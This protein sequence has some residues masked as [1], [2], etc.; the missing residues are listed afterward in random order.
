MRHGDVFSQQHS[1]FAG[2]SD[3]GE[4]YAFVTASELQG[5]KSPPTAVRMLVR[6]FIDDSLY[7]PNYGYFSKSVKILNTTHEEPF[8]FP[9][10]KNGSEFEALVGSRYAGM[11][12]DPAQGPGKQVW[13]TPTELFRPHYGQAIAKCLVS[14]YLL[15]YFPYEDL[16]IYE[17]GAGNGTLAQD[18]LDVIQ[19][20]YPDVYERTQYNIVEIS[21]TLADL[22][23]KRLGSRHG[24]VC[25]VIRRS[26]FD[27]DKRVPSPSFFVMMEVADNFSHD[28]IRY[29]TR[30]LEPYQGIVEI[31]SSGEFSLVYTPVMDP[32]ITSFLNLRSA[33]SH[34]LP[35]VNPLLARSPAL[36]SLLSNA[37][38]APNLT[39]PEFIP[40][41]LISLFQILHKYFPR[42]RLLLSDFSSLPDSVPGINAP[43]VQTRLRG[44]MVP[45]STFLVKQGFFDIFFPTD[46]ERVRDMYEHILSL[47]PTYNDP[48]S[49]TPHA[50]IPD[51]PT[52]L[53]PYTSSLSLDSG[54][55]FPSARYQVG[56]RRRLVEGVLS[57]SGLPVGERKSSVWS[58]REFLETYVDELG[59]TTLRNGENPMLE[60]YE[61]VKVLF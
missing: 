47:P 48:S 25:K 30:T 36:R 37:P 2:D 54:F 44:N 7:N 46:F 61:N 12:K 28:L 29:D 9:K 56:H 16:I 4:N 27:W 11:G 41:R 59:N 60:W 23:R 53:T 42:H 18:I 43:V 20:D 55:F 39:T 40:T 26:V 31:S 14:E 51:R 45:C 33:L 21:S 22:Q 8:K 50:V 15:K 24:G 1:L 19:E 35:S 13:H 32:L 34:P 5:H 49:S 6:D 3:A 57:A 10:I 17:I 38:F 52:P 58:H